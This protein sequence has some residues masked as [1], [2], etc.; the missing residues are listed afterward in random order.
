MVTL[1]SEDGDANVVWHEAFKLGTDDEWNRL[2]DGIVN[3]IG[4]NRTTFTT[5]G[6]LLPLEVQDRIMQ[7]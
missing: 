6:I 4:T 5:D 7:I 1:G 3:T 2:K